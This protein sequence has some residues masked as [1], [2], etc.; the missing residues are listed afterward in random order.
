LGEAQGFR[1]G[2]RLPVGLTYNQSYQYYQ[3]FGFVTDPPEHGSFKI[4]SFIALSF[5]NPSEHIR[6]TIW[7]QDDM[8]LSLRTT[9]TNKQ[10][11]P[12]LRFACWMLGKIKVKKNP[13]KC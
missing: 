12:F 6:T 8:T 3:S 10:M 9:Q 4:S 7:S 11:Y 2:H 13:T 5:A 1:G